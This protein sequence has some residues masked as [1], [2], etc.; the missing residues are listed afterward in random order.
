MHSLEAFKNILLFPGS[1][2]CIASLVYLLSL[3]LKLDTYST[4]A[5]PS[6]YTAALSQC[7]NSMF[8]GYYF[9]CFLLGPCM[10][11]SLIL[12]LLPDNQWFLLLQKIHAEVW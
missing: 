4:R 10:L 1:C 5:Y 9:T 7:F 11:N 8:T 2:S 6:L 12:L 3:L